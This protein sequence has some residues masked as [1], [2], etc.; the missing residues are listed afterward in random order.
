MSLEQ[1]Q[2]VCDSLFLI[3]NQLSKAAFQGLQ[4]ERVIAQRDEAEKEREAILESLE[5]RVRERTKEAEDSRIAALSL[6]EDAERQL[7]ELDDVQLAMLNMMEDLDEEKLKAE[8]ATKAKS[9]FL[10]NMSHEI[11]TPM[12][13]IIGMSHLALQTELDRKQR[14]YV[15]KVHRS[16]EALLGIIND[17]LDFSKIEAGKLSIEY[18]DFRL[19]DVFDNLAN[20]VGLKA[21]EK[22]VEL[23]FNLSPEVPTGLVG[24]ALRLGQILVNLGNNSV[25]FT[26]SGGEIV[27]SVDLIEQDE[28]KASLHFSVRDNGIGMTPEQQT[29]MFQ[30]FSQADASTTRKYGGTGLG[31]AISKKLT[32]LMDGEIWVE[33]EADVGSTFH[34]TARLGKQQGEA[35]TRRSAATD[36][37]VL[38]VLVVDDNSSSREILSSMLA[39]F[40][41]R[42]DQAGAGET[43]IAQ[44]EDANEK[45]PY[46]LVLMDWKMPGMDGVETT[47]AIQSNDNLTEVPTVIMVTAYGREAAAEAAAGVDFASVLT[48][49]VTPSTLL[50]AIMI[51]MGHEVVSETRSSNR[52]EEA[53]ADIAK[54]RGAKVLLVEDNEVN[55]ELALELLSMN[56][57][58]VEV[59]ND[60]QE[61]LELLDKEAFDG[62]LMDCQMPVMDGYTA[63]RK[64]RAQERYK[65]LPI[66]AMTANA[67][68]GDREKVMDAGM[69]EH[70]AKP[71]NVNE[72]FH[73]MARWIT[74]SHPEAA[75]ERVQETEI[76][77]PELDGIDTTEGLGRTQGNT[78]L[79]LKLLRKVAVSQANFISEFD[80]AVEDGDWELAQRLAHTLKGVAG[81][82]GAGQLQ[83]ACAALE[84]ETKEQRA[85][86]AE[87]EAA[88]VA[89]ERVLTALAS[90]AE[91]EVTSTEIALDVDAVRGVLDMLEQQLSDFDTGAQDTLD[92]HHELLSAGPLGPLLNSIERALG[93]YDFESAQNVLQQMRSQLQTADKVEKDVDAAELANVLKQ[94]SSL[95]ADYDTGAAEFLESKQALLMAAGFSSEVK[96]IIKALDD[97]DFDAAIAVVKAIAEKRVIKL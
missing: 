40:G 18:I 57:I 75:V 9:D 54:L 96:L 17:I 77:I 37:G 29:K 13:A 11:R 52:Q 86:A 26:E 82:I 81:G 6:M 85:E 69:N 95:I 53:A 61:A 31:L 2:A 23:M 93:D 27:V 65:D 1:F 71:I 51:A 47:R 44:L 67:M 64:L 38:R 63:T 34:F 42:V 72:M 60:G 19:E 88:Q 21:E 87:R 91:P 83:Q 30:S 79:Y 16:G 90:L 58:S 62:V 15:E 24:D 92:S 22:G 84:A 10:A 33:S 28:E 25:K 48:K 68:A 20:L 8:D 80:A 41:L 7:A 59:A 39:S 50:D 43:A 76:E 56:G 46:K 89:L 78:K 74:P 12:N 36:L 35:S 5:E 94:L 32:A 97:Y 66:L 45:D 73:S 4:Q 49:P 70:I 3:A 14:N 55:Q